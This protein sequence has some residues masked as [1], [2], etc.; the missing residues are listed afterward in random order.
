MLI[1]LP[2]FIDEAEP[3]KAAQRSVKKFPHGVKKSFLKGRLIISSPA[4]LGRKLL[5]QRSGIEN[6]DGTHHRSSSSDDRSEMIAVADKGSSGVA[7]TGRSA[8]IV[9]VSMPNRRKDKIDVSD[10]DL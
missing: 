1:K 9:Q 6:K 8:V 7:W 4:S 3:S 2:R 5:P 10:P